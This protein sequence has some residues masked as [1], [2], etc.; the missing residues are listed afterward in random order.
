MP[1]KIYWIDNLRAVACL[2]VIV[3]HTTTWYIT[4]RWR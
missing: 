4:G 1:Q 2:M 3:I